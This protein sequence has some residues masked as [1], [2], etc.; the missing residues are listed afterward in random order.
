M[1]MLERVARAL[2]V[3][4]GFDPDEDWRQVPGGPFAEVAIPDEERP[5]WTRY[6]NAA[7]AAITALM[8]PDE[9]MVEAGGSAPGAV[10]EMDEDGATIYPAVVYRA[11]LKAALEGE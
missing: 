5:R 11:M 3:A 7:R 10:S 6:R 2:C 8:E 4:D 1:T 9:G